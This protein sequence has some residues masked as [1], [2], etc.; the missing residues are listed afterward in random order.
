MEQG[1]LIPQLNT[2]LYYIP[3]LGI[4]FIYKV[5]FYYP[6]A[7]LGHSVDESARLAFSHMT[8]RTNGGAGGVV[9]VSKD[10]T[11]G[12]Y[13]TTKRM[14]WASMAENNI[15]KYG[16]DATEEIIEEVQS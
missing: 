9:I 2:Y 14:A 4:T 16:I 12:R 3:L 10:G 6:S 15:V 7:F 5:I 13:N 11:I 8:K 1:L